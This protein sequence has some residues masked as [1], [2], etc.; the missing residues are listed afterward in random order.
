MANGNGVGIIHLLQHP[1]SFSDAIGDASAAELTTLLE[2]VD[3]DNLSALAADYPAEVE[4][5]QAI[6]PHLLSL[7]EAVT[8]Q[9]G[10]QVAAARS[11]V[12]TKMQGVRLFSDPA[13][14]TREVRAALQAPFP[15]D[16]DRAYR[17]SAL[18][19]RVGE[20]SET[21]PIERGVSTTIPLHTRRM[22]TALFINHSPPWSNGSG[23]HA[24][25]MAKH[26]IDRGGR[27]GILFLGPRFDPAI[28]FPQ[29]LVPFRP[30]RG[31]PLEG[32]AQANM[33]VILSNGTNPAGVKIRDLPEPAMR[34]YV[35]GLSDA[36]AIA[37]RHLQAD[38][39]VANHAMV[40]GEA[41]RRTGLPYVVFCHGSCMFN[42][43]QVRQ[44]PDHY[45]PTFLEATMNGVRASDRVVTLTDDAKG[46]F[47]E[48]YGVP[49]DTISVIPNGF[50]E[51]TFVKMPSLR[52]DAVLREFGI[53]P[54]G[55]EHVVSYRGRMDPRKG[56]DILLH[57]ASRIKATMPGV[58]FVLAGDGTLLEQ[59][60]GL[61]QSLGIPRIVHFI[62]HRTRPE[63]ARLDNVS[64]LSI[65]VSRDEPFGIAAL[66]AAGTGTPVIATRVGGL[67][68]IVTKEI[69][70]LIEPENPVQLA[71]AIQ[72]A[73]Q[74]DLKGRI[75]ER[76]S[77]FVHQYHPWSRYGDM[78]LEELRRAMENRANGQRRER[79]R[80]S[81]R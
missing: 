58:H 5:L 44:A 27:A 7:K 70:L 50:D 3:G 54:T 56:V 75:G 14:L 81:A 28:S 21:L 80:A 36:V 67:Q 55:I 63:L 2:P 15:A 37:A 22:P 34:A 76:T 72:D 23:T 9:D 64:N 10:G 26:M 71:E 47:A 32:S 46:R 53:D 61:A 77:A 18:H 68:K 59:Y 12:L 13:A 25:A 11:R 4:D 29:Y 41:A 51:T 35:E 38:V 52:R 79:R 65:L 33:P 66:E 19:V 60:Q 78:L 24:I 73:L 74:I 17:A 39:I 30:Y 16:P 57:A 1:A 40:A 20:T 69:G 42:V 8:S 45:A 48:V 49:L 31:E 6:L 43:E 62:G